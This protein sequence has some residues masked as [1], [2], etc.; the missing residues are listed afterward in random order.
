MIKILKIYWRKIWTPNQKLLDYANT[1]K[2][3]S[4]IP[5][6]SNQ[7]GLT[8]TNILL[9]NILTSTAPVLKN[10][11][12]NQALI[13]YWQRMNTKQNCKTS[14]YRENYYFCRLNTE[15]D[16]KLFVSGDHIETLCMHK[17]TLLLQHKIIIRVNNL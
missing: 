13:T 17:R 4:I 1:H 16:S 3:L 10:N 14:P 8:C 2:R 5:V 12:S 9:A 11:T 7:C 15:Y 6:L